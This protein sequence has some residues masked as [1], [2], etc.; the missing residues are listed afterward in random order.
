[1]PANPIRVTLA[2]ICRLATLDAQFAAIVVNWYRKLFKNEGGGRIYCNV[3]VPC[4]VIAEFKVHKITVDDFRARLSLDTKYGHTNL[5][6]RRRRQYTACNDGQTIVWA[7]SYRVPCRY[8]AERTIHLA[9]ELAGGQRWVVQ[10]S[11]CGIRHREY[12]AFVSIGGL[13]ELDCIAKEA[14]K[15]IGVTGVKR[16]FFKAE[17]MDDVLSYKKHNLTGFIQLTNWSWFTYHELAF[18]F[19]LWALSVSHYGIMSKDHEHMASEAK[20]QCQTLND[21]ALE[22]KANILA[23]LCGDYYHQAHALRIKAL[24]LEHLGN[25]QDSLSLLQ[26]AR[27]LLDLCGMSQSALEFA[28]RMAVAIIHMACLQWSWTGHREMTSNCL[29]YMA[30]ISC[31]GP[32]NFDWAVTFGVI[33]LAFSKKMKLKCGLYSSLCSLGDM[34]LSNEDHT[35]AE[36]LFTVALEAFTEMD[37]HY[38]QANSAQQGNMSTAERQWRA[39]RPLF[40]RSLQ[41]KDIADIDCG[42]AGV[43]KAPEGALTTLAKLQAPTHMLTSMFSCLIWGIKIRD[44]AAATGSHPVTDWA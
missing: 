18:E 28:F 6:K 19:T 37:I 14:L 39:A 23:Q 32:A 8:I 7:W 35:T 22:E 27:E 16:Q 11:G 41:A 25:F 26:S 42:L 4:D 36:A 30:D 44:V 43:E 24:C 29:E 12:F 15:A 34:F 17:G 2:S 5:L 33:Y 3:R 20:A 10:C 1:M 31:W 21:P 13:D 40:E 9:V 38:A